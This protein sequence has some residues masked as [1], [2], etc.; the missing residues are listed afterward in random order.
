MTEQQ[1]RFAVEYASCG[2]AT[3]AAIKA[4]YSKE[5]ANRQGSRLLTNVDI[6]KMI[7]EIKAQQSQELRHKMAREASTAFNVLVSILNDP[8]AKDSDKIK[9]AID[10]LDR[11]GYVAE[12]KV[13]IKTNEDR[14]LERLKQDMAY[15]D[16]RVGKGSDIQ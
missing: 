12:K 3:Q 7:D 4:G 11:A 8:D 1:E 10:V 9:C 16:L 5:G 14:S 6:Q 15:D 2:N 13:E